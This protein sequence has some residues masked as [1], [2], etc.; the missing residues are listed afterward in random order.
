MGGTLNMRWFRDFRNWDTWHQAGGFTHYFMQSMMSNLVEYERGS[1]K[2]IGDLAE[3]WEVSND[4]KTYTFFLRPGAKFHDG[5]PVTS[6]D[7]LYNFKRGMTPAFNFNAQ[8]MAPIASMETPDD[9]TFRVT[10][11]QPSNSF[12]PELA[13]TFILI[14]PAHMPDMAAWQKNPVGN[15]PYKFKEDRP[16]SLISVVKGSDYFLKDGQ[17]RARPYIDA[18]NFHVI[19]DMGL[20]SSAFRSGR[21]DCACLAAE[22]WIN[23]QREL[24]KTDIPGVVFYPH[25]GTRMNVNFNTRRAP[26]SNLAFRQGFSIGLNKQA[27]AATFQSGQTIYPSTDFI[28]L[29]NGGLWAL[30]K[31]ELEKIPGWYPD[32]A[33][34]LEVARQK[35]RESGIDPKGLKFEFFSGSLPFRQVSE[36]VV[37]VASELGISAAMVEGS[38]ITEQADRR[39]AGNFQVQLFTE[40]ISVDDPVSYYSTFLS[41]GGSLNWTG[42]SNA[43]FDE[44]YR[45]QDVELDVA[46]RKQMIWEMQRI[47]YTEFPMFTLFWSQ[48]TRASRPFVKNFV[49]GPLNSGNFDFSEVWLD[50]A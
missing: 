14:Y 28:P 33:R 41:T 26:F 1:F 48:G 38:S 19:V 2:M 21:I 44:L 42:W 17:G 35:F 32:H 30:P 11:K 20:T 18:I 46:K 24:L 13:S 43:R 37:S 9:L 25:V 4:G 29:F 8:R 50:R 5:M 31:E 49:T 15:G 3:R 7:V 45:L 40:G 36:L 47:Q 39:N 23:D 12:L 22:G 16:D 27:I 10:V 6:K 34:N